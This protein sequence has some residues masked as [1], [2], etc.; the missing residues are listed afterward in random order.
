MAR[1]AKLPAQDRRLALSALAT[2]ASTRLT[3]AVLPFRRVRVI[4]DRW[5]TR[6]A[7]ST[8]GGVSPLDVRRA[9]ARA[10]P[11]V[12]GST[13]LAR[14]LAAEV[15]LRRHELP[16]RLTIGVAPGEGPGA[17]SLNAHAW[18]VSAGVMVTGSRVD[19]DSYRPL[20]TFEAAP[21]HSRA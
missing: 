7:R 5:S 14:A 18:T 3:L 8:T 13:C 20:V 2:L 6:G 17:S 9:V 12:P 4:I 10:T 21:D 11:F 1:F 15:I 16:V 19:L